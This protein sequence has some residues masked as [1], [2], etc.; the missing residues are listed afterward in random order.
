MKMATHLRASFIRLFSQRGPG[1]LLAVPWDCS[2]ANEFGSKH[3]HVLFAGGGE[4]PAQL[5]DEN[6][7]ADVAERPKAFDHVGLLVNGLPGMAG[8]PF[9]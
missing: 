1:D 3:G 8:L 5:V 7:K 9:I 4:S 2:S 6:K